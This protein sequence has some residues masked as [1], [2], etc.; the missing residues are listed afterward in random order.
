MAAPPLDNIAEGTLGVAWG[1]D[2]AEAGRSD[3]RFAVGAQVAGDIRKRQARRG[4]V[5]RAAILLI[6]GPEVLKAVL[7]QQRRFAGRG[8]HGEVASSAAVEPA[9]LVA[10]DVGQHHVVDA[11]DAYFAEVVYPSTGAEI[12]HY[13]RRAIAQQVDIAAVRVEKEIAAEGCPWACHERD[14]TQWRRD[15]Q[16]VDGLLT[17]VC[18]D[19]IF[20]IQP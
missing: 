1:G 2:G 13:P 17:V 7:L 14:D 11:F 5:G 8:V 20:T 10:V 16:G 9:A 6:T 4:V 18:V 12:D 19:G 3:G 15:G